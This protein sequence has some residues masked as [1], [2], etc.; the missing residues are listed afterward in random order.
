MKALIVL[1]GL[2]FLF[3]IIGYSMSGNWSGGK[4]LLSTLGIKNVLNSGTKNTVSSEIKTE[5]WKV[6]ISS[7]D[8]FVSN[9]ISPDLETIW[10]VSKETILSMLEKSGAELM[11]EKIYNLGYADPLRNIFCEDGEQRKFQQNLYDALFVKNDVSLI[12]WSL[13]ILPKEWV[14]LYLSGAD[15]SKFEND[16]SLRY[17]YNHEEQIKTAVLN[18]D[19]AG[20]YDI[21]TVYLIRQQRHEK[22]TDYK[23]IDLMVMLAGKK[24]KMSV[25]DINQVLNGCHNYKTGESGV[26]L[27]M[28]ALKNR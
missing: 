5:S 6:T 15:V 16:K 8:M 19:F 10:L 28:Q 7:E 2:I 21:A 1:F 4:S 12:S 13:K 26:D 3:V 17:L 23:V 18:K 25:N 9:M 27:M 22:K 14:E 11:F 24:H 20:L